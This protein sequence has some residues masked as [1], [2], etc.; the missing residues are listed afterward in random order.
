MP[1]LPSERSPWRYSQATSSA[2][3]FSRVIWESGDQWRPPLSPPY[4]RHSALGP[5][6]S[7]GGGPLAGAE[8]RERRTGGE[9]R[10]D[11]PAA[12]HRRRAL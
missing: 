1:S 2:P 4:S 12:T 7:R 9:E 6:R 8:G 10:E 5:L 11:V 3:T